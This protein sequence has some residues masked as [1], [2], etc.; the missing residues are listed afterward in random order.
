MLDSG[1]KKDIKKSKN[2]GLSEVLISSKKGS[3]K[4][5]VF[6]AWKAS[7]FINSP[8]RYKGGFNGREKIF[9]LVCYFYIKNKDSTK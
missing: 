8:L 2:K 4:T 7:L 9:G 1:R 3:L 6:T 5:Y